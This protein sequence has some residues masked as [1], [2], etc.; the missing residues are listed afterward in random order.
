M[1]DF[2]LLQSGSVIFKRQAI[3]ILVDAKAAKSVSVGKAAQGAQL[4]R[5]QPGL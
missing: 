1:L 4:I 2:S 3:R 5:L